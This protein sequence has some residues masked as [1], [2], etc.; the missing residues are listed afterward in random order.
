MR[1]RVRVV[2]RECARVATLPYR[3]AAKTSVPV[4]WNA[5]LRTE[6]TKQ[7][8]RARSGCHRPLIGSSWAHDATA[9]SAEADQKSPEQSLPAIK[10]RPNS[11]AALKRWKI[12]GLR[13]SRAIRRMKRPMAMVAGTHMRMLRQI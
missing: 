11:E 4:F 7:K 8:V 13:Q 9:P 5:T 1:G 3:G 10:Q 12:A 2:L 6:A